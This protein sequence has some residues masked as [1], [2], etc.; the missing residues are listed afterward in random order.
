MNPYTGMQTSLSG[1]GE[2]EQLE[3][4]EKLAYGLYGLLRICAAYAP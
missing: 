3:T 1:R 4:Q 2:Q